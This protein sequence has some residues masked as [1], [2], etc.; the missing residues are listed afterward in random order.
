QNV[1]NLST[2]LAGTQTDVSNLQAADKRNVKYDGAEGFET[3][4]LA[5]PNGTKLTNVKAAELSATSTDAVN[6]SQLYATNQTVAK[7][8]DSITQIGGQ[9]TQNTTDI[10][11]IGG[12]VTQNTTHIGALQQD[13]LQWSASAGAYDA[14]HGSG[15][16]QK[17]TNVQAGALSAT[18]TDAVNGSQLY[19]TNQQVTKNTTDITNLQQNV[20][21]VTNGKAGIVQQQDPNGQITVGAATD[22][23]S[24]NFANG[25]NADRVLTGVAAGVNNNDAVNVGQLNGGLSSLS[26]SVTNNVNTQISNL[27]TT[28]NSQIGEATKNAVQY[29]NDAHTSVTLGG[30]GASAPVSLHNVADGV[31]NND[32]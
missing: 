27:S 11:N 3:V 20:T 14:S 26:T 24:V 9:V 10:R 12:Q 17:I 18:S 31:A 4:T 25:S 22:G 1:T 2:S 5:G 23:T 29:D 30:Q 6:G 8:G 7:Q 15:S 28:I 13:A 19:A 32:A 21:N 16:A